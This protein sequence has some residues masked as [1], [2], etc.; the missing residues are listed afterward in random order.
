VG[1]FTLDSLYQVQLCGA[2]FVENRCIVRI[3]ENL[4]EECIVQFVCLQV[5]GSEGVSV[6][7][8]VQVVF[9]EL[10]GPLNGAVREGLYHEFVVPRET[11]AEAVGAGAG[12]L[13]K[14]VGCLLEFV[15]GLVVVGFEF[16]LELLVQ[17]CVPLAFSVLHIPLV[18]LCYT[19][20]IPVSGYYL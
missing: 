19:A 16:L 20:D 13:A 4:G 3:V 6:N 17:H 14:P 12:P 9:H 1:E 11:A 15:F 5:K 18:D 10:V 7:V 2:T 8:G